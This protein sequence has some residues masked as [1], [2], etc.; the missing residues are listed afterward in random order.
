MRERS[1]SN[2]NI[3]RSGE[4]SFFNKTT[5][6]NHNESVHVRKKPFKCGL[7]EDFFTKWQPVRHILSFHEG[8][9]LSSVEFVKKFT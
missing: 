2:V 5:L 9:N 6:K 1:L 7:C 8:K 4:N 3:V